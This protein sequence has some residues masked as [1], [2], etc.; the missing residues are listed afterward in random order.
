MYAV[1]AWSCSG[2]EMRRTRNINDN[3]LMYAVAVCVWWG[4]LVFGLSVF[5]LVLHYTG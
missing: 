3:F 1:L 4:C 2:E 5:V